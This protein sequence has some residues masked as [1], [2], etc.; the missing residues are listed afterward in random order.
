MMVMKRIQLFVVFLWCVLCVGADNTLFR[1]ARFTHVTCESG[2]SQNN[3]KAIA[4]D[5]D[6]FLWFGTK[7]GLNRYDG[8][9]IVRKNCSDGT[10]EGHDI[11]ALF[12]GTDGALWVGTES[13]LFVY[14]PKDDKFSYVD[15]KTKE[16]IG[17]SQ[18]GRAHV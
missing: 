7:N 18:I 17:I 8:R 10:V 4:K 3:V 13:G 6:G 1:N 14:Q 5:A 11:S 12:A 9:T 16:G 2:L 15:A